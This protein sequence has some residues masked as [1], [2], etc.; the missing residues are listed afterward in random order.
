V[1]AQRVIGAD[2]GGT[3]ILAGVVGREG[4]IVRRLE[5]PTP[6]E[7]QDALLAGLAQAVEALLTED[8]VAVGFGIPSRVDQRTGRAY[9]SVNIPLRDLDFRDWIADRFR[10][11]VGVDNDAN[12][13]TLAEWAFGAG[14]GT[15]TMAM[16][17]LGTGVGGGFVLDRKLY[18]GWAEVGHIVLEHEGKPCQGAC[19]GR[20][21]VESYCTGLA[22]GEAAREA[23]GPGAD[24]HELVRL[25]RGGNG[26]AIEIL[27]GI[28]RR[29]GSA[30]GTLVNLF[31][32]EV[33][34][35][36]GGF[37]AAAWEFLIEPARAVVRREALAPAG[38]TVRIVPAQLGTDAGLI[39]AGLI[40]FEALGPA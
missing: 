23:F 9:G 8:V 16:L 28:G 30:V 14:R 31:N 35:V 34:V 18:R 2:V 5:R 7:S 26:T 15:E 6:L 19:T 38:E 17:T 1:K 22:A 40:A 12:A 36:G 33:V 27:T 25:A 32:P 37:G 4:E 20:G 13:A 10:L 21:H 3:K 29:L 11:P 24:A 39:G